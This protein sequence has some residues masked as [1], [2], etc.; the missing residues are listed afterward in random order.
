[1]AGGCVVIMVDVATALGTSEEGGG[2]REEAYMNSVRAYNAKVRRERILA[3]LDHHDRM[4]EAHRRTLGSVINV[5][6][7][8][9]ARLEILLEQCGGTAA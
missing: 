5:H 4:I 9:I 7:A 8:E 6:S 1:V 2:E 3:W